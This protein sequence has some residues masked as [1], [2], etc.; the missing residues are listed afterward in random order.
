[1]LSQLKIQ[2][3]GLIDSLAI[4]FSDKLNIF[5]GETGAGKSI[6][7]DALR[8]SLGE[9]LD[10]SQVRDAD[11][12]CAVESVFELTDKFLKETPAFSEYISDE[13]PLLIINRT[14]LPDGRN[15]IKING[16]N[17]TVSQLKEIGNHLVDFHGANDHQMILAEESHIKII[18]RLSDLAA[19]KDE[20]AKKYAGYLNLQKELDELRASSK[21]REQDEQLL[22][23]Q[24]TELEQVTLDEANY[25]NILEERAR[26][27]NSEKLYEHAGELVKIF[28]DE[29]TGLD[30]LITQ[31]FGPMKALNNLDK[32]TIN[33]MEVLKNM[34]EEAQG[35]S[36][37]LSN[38]LDSLSFNPDKTKNINS[39]YDSYYEILRKYGPALE[40][41]EKIYESAKKKYELLVNLE[42]NDSKLKEEIQALRNELK[43]IADKITAKRNKTSKFLKETIEKE[44]KELGI[45]NIQFEARI[46]KIDFTDKGQDRVVFYMSPNIG[47]ELKPLA[48]IVSGGE[49]ARV[50]LAI[51]KALTKVDPIPV[52]VFDE[53]DAQ[54]GGR[55]GDI[56]GKKLKELSDNRQV[57]LITHLPQIAAFSDHHFKVTKKV[58]DN[59][60]IINVDLLDK[61]ARVEELA[62][63]MSG[64]KE[65]PIA[66]K[67]AREMLGRVENG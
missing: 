27:N 45:K 13:D 31:A 32:G 23:H 57:I 51:K 46:D 37:D 15:R 33:F 3:F 4:D 64:E 11:K 10:S 44:L 8:F 24:I 26:M 66:L 7:I 54:I 41:A 16:F 2:N 50:M 39:Q 5:T 48:Q 67:H 28:E 30:K 34:Q 18:D 22:K 60:T 62:K 20:Y 53:I 21:N 25:R 35:L 61:T 63:M 65:S 29:E 19:E 47:E 1:M 42:Y 49:S 36:H 59:R 17:I 6:L 12:P 52:L 58:K 14:Y 43:K 56:T 40:D 55:L 9:R 38:Y